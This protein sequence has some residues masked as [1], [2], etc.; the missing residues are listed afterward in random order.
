[1]K[2]MSVILAVAAFAVI[3]LVNSALAMPPADW[4][5]KLVLGIVPTDS[6]ANIT[7]RW[8]NLV[9]YLEKRLAVPI[10]VKVATDYAG[11]ITGMQ[12]KHV[13][14]AYFGP[15]SYVEAAARANADCFAIEVG[16]DGT[17]GYYGYIITKKGSPL[18]TVADL[19]GKVWAFV[20]PNST[21]GTLVPMVYFMNEL[22]IDPEKYF[23]KVIYAGSHEASM[24]AVKAGRI[25][26]ASTNDL[27]MARGN[28]KLWNK[29]KDFEIIWT[30]PLIPGSLMAYRKDLAPTL[31]K[32]LA[33]GFLAYND[34]AGLELLKL[35]RYDPV[36]DA[37]Y[38][39]IRQLIAVQKS[40][41]K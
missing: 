2:R 27:D 4:P 17:N 8:D 36:K 16:Q 12:F 35:K 18:K 31:K 38:D 28:G 23:S 11:V 41:K 1:M 34:P 29:E 20:D 14:F 9:K 24:M 32:A 26:G 6:S 3:T 7:E 40:M 39:P 22:K 15:K 25:D 19:K 21:S 13:D 37:T 33:E 10:E 30:S 5:R